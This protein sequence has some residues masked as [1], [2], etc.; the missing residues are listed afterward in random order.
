MFLC[1]NVLI[2]GVVC[3]LNSQIDLVDATKNDYGLVI[4]MDLL[5]VYFYGFV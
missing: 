2:D 5:M 1:D 4:D 3:W